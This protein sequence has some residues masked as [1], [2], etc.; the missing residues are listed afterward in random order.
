MPDPHLV[1][2]GGLP[3]ARAPRAWR[4]AD[5]LALDIGPGDA[6]H[7]PLDRLAARAR[8]GLSDVSADLLAVAAYVFA[9][10]Q[11]VTRGGTAGVDYGDAWRRRFRLEVP[12]RRPDVWARPAVHAA[13]A[14][15][16]RVLTDDEYE[17]GFHPDPDPAPLPAYLYDAVAPGRPEFDEVV[18]FSGGLDSLGGAVDE[19]LVRRRRVVL[20]SHRAA[21]RVGAR[22]DALFAALAARVRPRDP[23]PAHLGVVVNK[24]RG[25]N[26]DFTQRTRSLVF[27]AAGAAVARLVGL[28]RVRFYEN[29]VTSLNHP[30]SP[31]LVGARASR[32]THPA[33]L[34]RLGA[35]LSAVYDAPF[36]VDNPY[37]GAT[38]A[39]LCGWLKGWGHA[40]LC[41]LTCSCGSVWG[42]AEAAPHCGRC[43]Q[44]VDR[45]VAVL[46]AGLAG[47]DDPPDRY[48]SDPLA[49]ERDGAALTYAERYVGSARE[50]AA[51]G[52]PRAFAVRF[53]EVYDA[54]PHLGPSVAAGVAAAH[55]LYRRHAAGVE[56]GLRAGMAARMVGLSWDRP[57]ARSLLGLV[58]NEP[59]PLPPP[60]AAPP[61]APPDPPP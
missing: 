32:T 53:P 44:C 47:A 15:A 50:A 52:S 38:K 51:V 19:V 35:L 39:E 5:R 16:L 23:T 21:T 59:I 43:S 30:V 58:F 40:D 45:R 46:A 8:T 6:V 26:R 18:L 2:C 7:L 25:L 1:L 28:W 14:D 41:A 10:D 20:V 36:G 12:V 17:F 33:A 60:A 11:A 54:A 57:P 34:D 37:Q 22:Q 48:E 4:A 27:A 61:A 55:D 31:E 56:R 24:R 29:G 3:A 42:K 13:L 49:G 9:A